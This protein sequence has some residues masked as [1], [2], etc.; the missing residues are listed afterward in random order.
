MPWWALTYVVLYG[1]FSI[2]GLADDR[3]SGRGAPWLAWGAL[4][5]AAETWLVVAFFHEE[6]ARTVGV[7][8]AG[9]LLLSVTF[10]TTSVAQDLRDHRNDRVDDDAGVDEDEAAVLPAAILIAGLLYAPA[11]VLGSLVVLR[12]WPVDR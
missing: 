6:V 8:A 1:L 9:F 12:S 7:L 11:F 10:A 2:A 5:L 4:A 3:A